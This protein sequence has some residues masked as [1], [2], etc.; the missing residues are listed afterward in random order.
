MKAMIQIQDTLVSLDVIEQY[1][2]CDFDKCLGACC[3]E[4]DAGAPVSEDEIEELEEAME[5]VA[6]D[7][8]PAG[9]RA[10]DEQG[11]V[12]IDCEGELGTT[13][14]DGRECAF[15]TFGPGGMTLCALEKA[16]REGRSRWC[17]P[18]SC[19]LYPVRL[20]DYGRYIAVNYDRWKVCRGAETKG[21]ALGLRVYQFLKG[22]LIERFGE[23]WYRELSLTAE[24]WLRQNHK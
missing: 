5:R 3:I 17:K 6:D 7:L 11:V 4:G 10:I 8:T 19:R 1:F 12:S 16:Y 20:K 2:C 24:E 22:P 15:C 13:I 21:R 14:V 23:E 9:R 18:R